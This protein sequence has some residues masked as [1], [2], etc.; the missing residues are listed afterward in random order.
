[1]DRQQLK[2]RWPLATFGGCILAYCVFLLAYVA[3]APDAR[4][5]F[6]LVD[7]RLEGSVDRPFRWEGIVIQRTPGLRQIG[8]KPTAGDRLKEVGGQKVVTALDYYRA[9]QSLRSAT[10]PP[11]S[12]FFAGGDPLELGSPPLAQEQNGLLY[13]RA[14]FS[15]SGTGVEHTTY[16][17]VQSVPVEDVGLTLAWFIL[18]LAIFSVAA[19]AVWSRPFDRPAR[20]FYVMCVFTMGAFV[21]GFHWWVIAGHLWLTLPFATCAVLLPVVSL[22]FFVMYPRPKP[23]AEGRSRFWIAAMYAIPA[24][25]VVGLFITQLALAWEPAGQVLDLRANYSMQWLGVLTTGIY[26]YMGIAA[27]Y[28]SGIIV[29]LVY[30]VLTTRNAIEHNQVR[31]ILGAGLVATGFIGY[32]LLLAM[33]SRASFALGGATI[34]MF[35]ASLL[36]MLAYAIG[37]GRYKLM[38]LDQVVSRGMWYYVL[39]YS[40]SIGFALAVASA[41]L[42]ATTWK[43]QLLPTQ[44]SVLV[45]VVM[46]AVGMLMW[47]RDAA[48][49]TIDR[50]FFREKYQLDK[51]LQRMNRAVGHLADS[52]LLSERMA[53]SCRDV[54]QVERAAIYLREA[55]TSTFH[56]A[57]AEGTGPQLPLNYTTSTAFIETLSGESILQ[58]VPV[59]GRLGLTPIQQNLRDLHADLVSGLEIDGELVGI[60]V[61][62]PKQGSALYSG[63]DMTF[64]SAMAQITSVALHCAKVHQGMTRLNEELRS[65]VDRIAQQKIQILMLQSELS[66]TQSE[67][68]VDVRV[69]GPDDERSTEIKREL[70]KGSSPGLAQVLEVVRK[71]APT[72][73]TVLLRGESGTGKE[74]LAKAIHENSLRAD[75]PLVS[76]H[77]AALSPAL[78]ESE[79]FGHVKGAF[80]GATADKPGRFE[81]ANGGTLF[82]DEIGDISL[83][84]QIK[85]LRVIQERTFEPVGS[86]RSVAAN[87]RLITATHQNLEELIAQGRFREDL[88]YRLNVVSVS[89]PPL[90]ERREDIVELTMHFLHRAAKANGKS[91]IDLDDDAFAALQG[92]HWP[93]NIRELQN[94]IERAVV[95]ADDSLIR[96]EDLPVEIRE[97]DR[98]TA[99][100]RPS[101]VKGRLALPFR[102]PKPASA[103]ARLTSERTIAATERK[104]SA[105][106]TG[107]IDWN[108]LEPG[109]EIALLKKALRECD[110]NKTRAAES[111]GLPRSTYFSKLKKYQIDAV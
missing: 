108:R 103:A 13:V 50:R 34:P 74:S 97:P 99:Q 30:S 86:G 60:V 53:G 38:L 68:A 59:S 87:V 15:H 88:Y 82:L 100:T 75:H 24:A 111:L 25:A 5:R 61:L 56:L 80:T 44:L 107:S 85:L 43:A 57:A 16:L 10:P 33:T 42:I 18:Q 70:I 3:T 66:A 67:D 58:R 46:M 94:V 73:A 48:Q 9:M 64:L 41:A 102:K 77:C 22:H 69:S 21:G 26:S 17:A 19:L 8:P 11:G 2:V 110:G 12:Q 36:F 39:S 90:R 89:L 6:L 14:R 7:S 98:T 84:T 104:G 54:L 106:R 83:E 81:L 101:S 27:F 92:Y 72:D 35:I 32:T 49:R 23:F 20:L 76:V 31:S 96:L 63:E 91:S 62:G 95:L 109:E 29:S 40:V 65:K 93:G 52:Q 37:I 45:V 28:F 78:L 4:L 55:K 1:M 79:L 47:A 105:V 71:A 51:A